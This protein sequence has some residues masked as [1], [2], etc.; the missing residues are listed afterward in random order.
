MVAVGM[1]KTK[2]SVILA[3][4]MMLMGL[5]GIIAGVIGSI[6]LIYLMHLH[7]LRFGGDTAEM[8]ASYG[9]EAIMPFAWQA[10]FFFGQAGVVLLIFLIAILYPLYATSKIKVI[11]A[12]RA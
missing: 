8:M 12:L 2:L 5:S 7:P 10:D 9:Y 1:Q 4:E 3:Y 6:P 11:K